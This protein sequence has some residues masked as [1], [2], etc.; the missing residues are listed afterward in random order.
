MYK[1]LNQF[2]MN[3]SRI[4]NKYLKWPSRENYLDY[5]KTENEYKNLVKKLNEMYF[6][7]NAREGSAS[8][9]S[10]WNTVNPFI[11]C[12]G[13]L[14]NDKIII[15]ALNNTTLSMKGSNLVFIKAKDE[16]RN[17]KILV[18]MFNNHYINREKS[19]GS[20]PK[21]IG[22]QSNPDHDKWTVENIIQCYKNHPSII[23][24]KE[25]FKNSATFG[26]SKP[27]LENTSLIVKSLIHFKC[28]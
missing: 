7:K 19:A 6:Q 4:K 15:K 21:S 12:K 8:S 9:K 24:I 23:K 1:K 5:K 28:Y 18:E 25:N 10:F 27:I 26:Y 3:K 13:T 11:S 17:E 2:I 16:I 20:A 14:S 22:N